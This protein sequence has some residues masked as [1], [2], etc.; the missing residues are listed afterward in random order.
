MH[1]HPGVHAEQSFVSHKFDSFHNGY[2]DNSISFDF[3]FAR[4]VF[5]IPITFV[6]FSIMLKNSSD[7]SIDSR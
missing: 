1:R 6:P 5:D 7:F 4:A 2:Q 3:F